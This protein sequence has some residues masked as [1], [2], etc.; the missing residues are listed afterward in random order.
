MKKNIGLI[1]AVLI[2]AG[3]ATMRLYDTLKPNRDNL[4]KLSIGMTKEQVLDL[5]GTKPFVC[6]NMTIANPFRVS[7]LQG[8]SQMYEVLY[9]VVKV[10]TDDNI[11]DENELIPLILVDG[12][13]AGWG[14]DYLENVR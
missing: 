4:G 3:C 6:N 9:Y 1:L 13:L 2:I 12:K 8:S 7:M 10:V 14:W 11:I 5:M